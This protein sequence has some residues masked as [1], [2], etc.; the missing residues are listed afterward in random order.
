M[1]IEFMQLN[2]KSDARQWAS[3][4]GLNDDSQIAKL[5]GE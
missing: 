3:D 5:K 2:S 4:A 1:K